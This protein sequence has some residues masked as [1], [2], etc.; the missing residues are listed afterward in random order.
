MNM[1]MRTLILGLVGVPV[2]LGLVFL[3]VYGEQASAI[4]QRIAPRVPM[5]LTGSA[6]FSSLDGGFVTNIVISLWSMA[7]AMVAGA[8]LGT[9]LIARSPVV[10]LP[11]S[12][13][14]N[15]LRNSPWLVV[16]FAM[17]YLLPFEIEVFGLTISLSPAVKAVI[18][19]ALPVAANIAEIFRGGVQAIPSGQ[20]ESASSLGYRR[21]QILRHVVIPQALPLMVP[22]LMTMYSM[23]FIGTSLV[24]VTGAN[25][26]LSVARTIIAVDGEAIATAIYIFVLLLFFLFCF[27]IAILTRRLEHRVGTGNP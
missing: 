26:V 8:A 6:D 12:L 2:L 24:V 10:R 20:W 3:S 9:G 14:M 23:L 13:I 22:N 5:L 21:L 18:G 1:Q 25:D 4:I 17:L 11:C 19:L 16:L 7:I 15:L 27:P